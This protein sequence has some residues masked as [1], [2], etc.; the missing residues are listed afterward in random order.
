MH[1]HPADRHNGSR[2]SSERRIALF[3]DF[4]NLR[5]GLEDQQSTFALSEPQPTS[6]IVAPLA[7][8]GRGPALAY[9]AYVLLILTL[10]GY[11]GF[12]L[13][14]RLKFEWWAA[15]CGGVMVLLLPF[16]QW[17]LGVLHLIVMCGMVWT[18]HALVALFEHPRLRTG[19]CV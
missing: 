4:D 8:W 6:A 16:V 9:N 14:R 12:R 3:V 18:L 15:V 1:R 17:K 19:V 7:W 10:N 2:H 11:S 13:L 5:A